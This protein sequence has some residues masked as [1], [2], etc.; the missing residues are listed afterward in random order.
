MDAVVERV[1]GAAEGGLYDCELSPSAQG[2]ASA[3]WLLL[4]FMHVWH[5]ED[6]SMLK[7]L[8]TICSTHFS[9]WPGL[10]RLQL[11]SL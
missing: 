6:G 3:V 9:E 8:T 11:E 2:I 10:I 7:M 1:E 5:A 4:C